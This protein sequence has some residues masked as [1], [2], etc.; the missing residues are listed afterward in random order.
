MKAAIFDGVGRPLRIDDL[1]IPEPADD[2]V[3]LRVPRA[4][5]ADPTCI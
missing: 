5:S 2:E 3:L 4:A 1:D